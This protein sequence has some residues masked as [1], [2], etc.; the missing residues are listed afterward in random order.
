MVLD[1]LLYLANFKR[2]DVVRRVEFV[3]N[4]SDD[5]IIFDNDDNPSIHT[6][7]YTSEDDQD[8]FIQ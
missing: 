6:H 2:Q 4:E 8:D 7:L 1:D 5:S 3:I